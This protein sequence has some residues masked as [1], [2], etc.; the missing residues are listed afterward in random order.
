LG[1]QILLAGAA[2]GEMSRVLNAV[3]QLLGFLQAR[4]ERLDNI[5]DELF[6][7]LVSAT[8]RCARQAFP[9]HN[10]SS[11][12]HNPSSQTAGTYKE[13][14]R[15]APSDAAHDQS[16]LNFEADIGR[17][18]P[19]PP[20]TV[21]THSDGYK[22]RV[23]K[24]MSSLTKTVTKNGW[25]IASAAARAIARGL[26]VSRGL[27]EGD[28]ATREARW[29]RNHTKVLP[30][31]WRIADDFDTCKTT[32]HL[33]ANQFRN[34]RLKEQLRVAREETQGF[35]ADATQACQGVQSLL[36]ITGSPLLPTL[37]RPSGVPRSLHTDALRIAYEAASEDKTNKDAAHRERGQGALI[38]RGARTRTSER[39]SDAL[40][41]PLGGISDMTVPPPARTSAGFVQM[42]AKRD[43]S[44]TVITAATA[45][46]PLPRRHHRPV[47]TTI[48]TT[49]RRNRVLRQQQ[50]PDGTYHGQ[51]E[52]LGSVKVITASDENEYQGY[53]GSSSLVPRDCSSPEPWRFHN[54][55]GESDGGNL[56]SHIASLSIHR[57]RR[58]T[59]ATCASKDTITD[60]GSGV[61]TD[62]RWGEAEAGVEV[63]TGIGMKK[64]LGKTADE[65]R[66]TS[67]RLFCRSPVLSKLPA[68]CEQAPESA[69][70]PTLP[71][72]H[73][74]YDGPADATDVSSNRLFSAEFL[75]SRGGM[76]HAKIKGE[77]RVAKTY[78][79]NSNKRESYTFKV[80]NE[81]QHRGGLV[82][83]E[84]LPM[85][86]SLIDPLKVAPGVPVNTTSATLTALTNDQSRA[87]VTAVTTRRTHGNERGGGLVS[88]GSLHR[89][90][91]LPAVPVPAPRKQKNKPK[92]AVGTDLLKRKIIVPSSAVTKISSKADCWPSDG[93]SPPDMR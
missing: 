12:Q 81:E 20:P 76:E 73:A 5:S 86:P 42:E 90:S 18:A 67:K 38:Y 6:S 33:L 52:H 30:V 48:T 9:R 51:N 78:N 41:A 29:I 61:G 2:G 4:F 60:S 72:P 58:A 64:N 21:T 10:M 75:Q 45:E 54:L 89:N 62:L 31:R 3:E 71:L 69:S 55:D 84:T 80:E 27:S 35:I 77:S 87:G 16:H 34:G 93:G 85:I 92:S 24:T 32:L 63:A 8:N 50:Q 79:E 22:S 36:T 28:R 44:T 46:P 14:S 68:R 65:K 15:P 88:L 19:S 66:G 17:K 57:A 43:S 37:P 70:S 91:T 25:T 23:R 83:V 40:N 39:L 11:H 82:K 1:G 13:M 47:S 53:Q 26:P 56:S 7:H 49:Q 59:T 74:P